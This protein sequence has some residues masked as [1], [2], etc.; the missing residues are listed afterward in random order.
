MFDDLGGDICGTAIAAKTVGKMLKSIALPSRTNL[1]PNCH[2]DISNCLY[3]GLFLSYTRSCIVVDL[4]ISQPSIQSIQHSPQQRLS[5]LV[6][7]LHHH[8]RK[9]KTNRGIKE[10]LHYLCR[11]AL[12]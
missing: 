1:C 12:E 6:Y 7:V 11:I 8:G 10:Q 9:V 3:M 2:C 4:C 5:V